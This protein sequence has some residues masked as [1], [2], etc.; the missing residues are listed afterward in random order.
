M[1]VRASVC[2]CMDVGWP[3]RHAEDAGKERVGIARQPAL[4][5]HHDVAR[6]EHRVD[7]EVRQTAVAAL[8]A[9]LWTCV[10]GMGTYM[11]GVCVFLCK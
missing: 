5:L 6:H 3:G 8:A 1:S 2:V 10:C 7:G 4:H 11:C 9:H